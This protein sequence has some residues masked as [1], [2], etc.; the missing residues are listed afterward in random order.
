MLIQ[1]EV[2]VATFE[3]LFAVFSEIG[4]DFDNLR[5]VEFFALVVW[6]IF[7]DVSCAVG[8]LLACLESLF[9]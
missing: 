8:L 2:E 5:T 6:E 1:S 3:C 4:S 9:P 7:V